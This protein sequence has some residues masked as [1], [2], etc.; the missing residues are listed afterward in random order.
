MSSPRLY[1]VSDRRLTDDLVAVAEAIVEAVPP[2]AAAIQLREKDLDARALC[3]LA[4]RLLAVCRPR[5]CP[6]LI[7]DRLD[8][9][10]AVG[11]DG[12][13]LPESGLDIATVRR[14]AGR[15][16]LIGASSHSPES[17]ADRM[18]Q[19][20]DLVVL[21]P[22]WATPSKARFGDPLGPDALTRARS[23]ALLAIGGIDSPDRAAAAVQAGAH[24]IA[25]IRV[26]MAAPDPGRAARELYDAIIK[27]A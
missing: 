10:L 5:R 24:G 7:N 22:I 17:A 14:L 15:D 8:V 3:A 25:A 11:A 9:A 12:V 13:H 4:R 19:G 18:R 21:G 26:F 6:V 16:L 20:A 27:P 23:P 1:I 2:G